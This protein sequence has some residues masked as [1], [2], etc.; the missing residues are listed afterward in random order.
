MFLSISLTGGVRTSEQRAPLSM[1]D[2]CCFKQSAYMMVTDYIK[3]NHYR[4]EKYR[5]LCLAYLLIITTK[6]AR[7]RSLRYFTMIFISCNKHFPEY[8]CC[9]VL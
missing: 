1:G 2:L 9:V 6:N 7:F 3:L 8:M 4:Q 5:M